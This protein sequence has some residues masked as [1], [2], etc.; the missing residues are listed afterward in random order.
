MAR[1]PE[2]YIKA[3]RWYSQAGGKSRYFGKVDEMSRAEATALL[4]SALSGVA[5]EP[6]EPKS[7][8]GPA[9]EELR[10]A[11]LAWL[12]RHRSPKNLRERTRHSR[13]FAEMFAGRRAASIEGKDVERFTAWMRSRGWAEDYVKK[14]HASIRAMYRKGVQKRWLPPCDPFALLEPIQVPAK[15]LREEDLP[16]REEIQRLLDGATGLLKDLLVLYMHTGARTHE[17]LE[18]RVGDYSAATKTLCLSKHKRSNTLKE[19]APRLILLNDEADEVVRRL[20]GGRGLGEFLIL[21]GRGKPY[22]S[23]SINGR[24]SK[25]RKSLGIRPEVT[26]YAF[27]HLMATDLLQ[28]GVDSLV[29]AK[30]LGTSVMMLDRVYT[31]WR[32]DALRRAQDAVDRMR[33]IRS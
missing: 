32:T 29:V 8:T 15:V 25:L 27:R 5:P 28:A 30:L 1:R 31:H 17:L 19:A 10:D 13:P 6:R 2:V 18:A 33:A 11:Y 23:S 21:N 7:E 14:H 20:A 22:D 4:W 16:T 12:A 3:G 24:F 9:V 26:P